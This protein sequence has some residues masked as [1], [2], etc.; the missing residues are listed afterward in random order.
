MK[1][2]HV[3]GLLLWAPL[4][5]ACSE[6]PPAGADLVDVSVELD[7]SLDRQGDAP[8]EVLTPDALTPRDAEESGAR[9]VRNPA[10]PPAEAQGEDVEI[11]WRGFEYDDVRY[12]CNTCPNGLSALEGTWRLLDFDT[13]DPDVALS[14]MW[15]QTF[16]FEGNRWRQLAEWTQNGLE[17]E[18]SMEGWFWCASKPEVNNEAKVFVVSELRP[19]DAFGYA[20]SDVFTA[21]LLN[22]TE[23]GD[24]LAFLFY[25]GFNTGDQLAEVYC[26]VGDLVETLAGETKECLDPWAP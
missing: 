16:V 12:T 26:R 7:V 25:E 13:E 11:P 21:D 15:L 9:F 6:A 23:G 19:S 5:W 4:V 3:L 20:S 14:D 2:I 8:A 10:C 18:A 22:S 17:Q 24:K 1:H